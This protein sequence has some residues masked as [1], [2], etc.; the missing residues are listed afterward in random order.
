MP[1]QEWRLSD[2]EKLRLARSRMRNNPIDE[3]FEPRH[4]NRSDNS[5]K[6]M[7][8]LVRWRAKKATGKFG[9]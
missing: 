6:A 9:G 5:R 7:R 3:R 2:I 4:P 1:L 8:S